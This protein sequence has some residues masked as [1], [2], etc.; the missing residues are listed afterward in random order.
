MGVDFDALQTLLLNG[1]DF[2]A[3]GRGIVVIVHKDQALYLDGLQI[4]VSYTEDEDYFFVI[5]GEDP[6]NKPCFL[7]SSGLGNACFSYAPSTS[8]GPSGLYDLEIS[9][10][11]AVNSGSGVIAGALWSGPHSGI[12]VNEVSSSD[13]TVLF[14]IGIGH[15]IIPPCN[16]A[17]KGPISCPAG[18][19]AAIGTIASNGEVHAYHY[20]TDISESMYFIGGYVDTPGSASVTLTNCI[21][22]GY[23]VDKT[24]DVS[25]LIG[26]PGV[27]SFNFITSLDAGDGIVGYEA[28]GITPLPTEVNVI[29]QGTT[30]LGVDDDIYG[31]LRPQGIGSDI[32]S[33]EVIL[34]ATTVIPTTVGS[35]TLPPTTPAP[36]T[37]RRRGIKNFGFSHRSN[38]RE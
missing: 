37:V 36:A 12:V 35:T 25:A 4:T 6:E 20:I 8:D 24:I 18:L 34:G 31:T 7:Q 1:A 5:I 13:A 10:T 29:G 32:G 3:A 16:I 27:L 2:V 23:T 33:V 15:G 19:T 28:D 30:I 11:N 26:S 21:S 9:I 17:I 38:W 22:Q 14:A